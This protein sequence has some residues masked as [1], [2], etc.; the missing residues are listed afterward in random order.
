MI[1]PVMAP[2]ARPGRR[3]FSSSE[4]PVFVIPVEVREGKIPHLPHDLVASV[5]IHIVSAFLT[6]R[7]Q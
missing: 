6:W 5:K 3:S 7:S 2:F 4:S 1:V